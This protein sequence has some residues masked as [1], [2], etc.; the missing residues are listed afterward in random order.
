MSDQSPFI[1]LT[2]TGVGGRLADLSGL[3]I[4]PLYRV[5]P[6]VSFLFTGTMKTI[7]RHRKGY[8]KRGVKAD[9]HDFCVQHIAVSLHTPIVLINPVKAKDNLNCI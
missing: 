7:C 2:G 6:T 9:I 5:R 1:Q 3:H 8:D 4:R